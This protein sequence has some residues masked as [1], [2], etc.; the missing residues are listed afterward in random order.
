MPEGLLLAVT[1]ESVVVGN[2]ELEPRVRFPMNDPA[3]VIKRRLAASK[4]FC[5]FE[6]CL[7]DASPSNLR[8]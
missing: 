5:W 4:T 6:P 2:Q 7:E 8:L 1:N 3:T